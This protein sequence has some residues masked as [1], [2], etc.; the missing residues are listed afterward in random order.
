MIRT[1]DRVPELTFVTGPDEARTLSEL[2]PGPCVLVF[3]RHLA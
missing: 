1:G 2:C 3:L